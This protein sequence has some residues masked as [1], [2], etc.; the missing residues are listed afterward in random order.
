MFDLLSEI[1]NSNGNEVAKCVFCNKCVFG[2][3][4]FCSYLFSRSELFG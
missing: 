2:I 3:D 4:V 1:L